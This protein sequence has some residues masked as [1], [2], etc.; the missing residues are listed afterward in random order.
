MQEPSEKRS[1]SRTTSFFFPSPLLSSL[2]FTIKLATLRAFLSTPNLTSTTDTQ[3][4]QSFPFAIQTHSFAPRLQMS[5]FAAM[6]APTSGPAY[7]SRA[8]AYHVSRLHASCGAASLL[9]PPQPSQMASSPSASTPR[10][11]D[12]SSLRSSLP[13]PSAP[14]S[15]AAFPMLMVGTPAR[16]TPPCTPPFFPS[17]LSSSQRTNSNTSYPSL[18]PS[19]YAL[20]PTNE[21]VRAT[22]PPLRPSHSYYSQSSSALSYDSSSQSS[23]TSSSLT[24][25]TISTIWTPSSSDKSTHS[26]G[27]EFEDDE[28]EKLFRLSVQMREGEFDG[29]MGDSE[30]DGDYYDDGMD[31]VESM[32]ME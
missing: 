18:S 11:P 24:A 1:S 23:S 8:Y 30:W 28:E 20:Y 5:T 4:I 22:R 27:L 13:L 32:D 31:G 12:L 6:H 9:S 15:P 17:L 19:T 26:L 10:F 21:A 3:R 7:S 25:T 14:T 2:H 29:D 16:E